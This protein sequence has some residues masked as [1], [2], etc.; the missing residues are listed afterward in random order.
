MARLKLLIVVAFVAMFVAGWIMGTATERAKFVSKPP[1][2]QPNHPNHPPQPGSQGWLRNQLGLSADQDD[3]I[4]AIW[5]PLASARSKYMDQWQQI[6][7]DRDESVRNLLTADQ[8]AAVDA[9]YSESEAEQFALE[10]RRDKEYK[11]A[12]TKTKELLTPEQQKKY[13]NI[14]AHQH[15][16]RGRFPHNGGPGGPGGPPNG[17][18]PGGPPPHD[19]G[20]E[21]H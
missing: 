18:G 1:T 15:G 12:V 14:L 6:N 11:D 10:D 7:H 19:R 16:D 13:E 5:A 17:P 20:H 21:P 9:I 2:T 4:K 8:K 3:K